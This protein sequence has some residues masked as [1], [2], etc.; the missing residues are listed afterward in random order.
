MLSAIFNFQK[1]NSCRFL[2]YWNFKIPKAHFL[3]SS[4]H[5]I[6]K[7]AWFQSLH[8][9]QRQT[10]LVFCF[11][12]GHL[13]CYKGNVEENIFYNDQERR[14][15]KPTIPKY[16]LCSFQNGDWLNTWLGRDRKMLEQ[17]E[18][19]QPHNVV[20]YSQWSLKSCP[21]TTTPKKVISI[22]LLRWV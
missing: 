5:R 7:L 11:S 16:N 19:L 1:I 10:S 14:W 3:K 9:Q 8:N 4:Y 13:L 18:C 17:V 6:G 2:C 22:C 20:T 15:H 12:L 21:V